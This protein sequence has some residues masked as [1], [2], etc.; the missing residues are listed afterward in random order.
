[1]FGAAV[2]LLVAG[3]LAAATV[4]RPAVTA[5]IRGVIVAFGAL[6]II[7][8]LLAVLAGPV[9]RKERTGWW[10]RVLEW[11]RTVFWISP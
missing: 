2:A 4:N 5:T 7:A 3:A 9:G 11:C 6:W 10:G 1:M 8:V